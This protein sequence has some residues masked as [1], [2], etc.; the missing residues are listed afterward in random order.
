M[1]ELF[2]SPAAGFDHPIEILEGCH[3][4]IRRNCALVQRV[5]RHVAAKGSDD[6]ARTAIRT[7]MRYFDE[8]GANHHRDE[9]ED[10]FPALE[11]CAT[12]ADEAPL[13][14]LLERLRREH[15]ELDA[16][17]KEMREALEAVA[18]GH[19]GAITADAALRFA[20][21]YETH[22]ALEEASLFPLAR[23]LLEAPALDA[24]GASMAARRGVVPPS[25]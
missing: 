1:D 25:R 24:L 18:G 9:E 21:A 12:G 13:A 6:E 4:R 7:V 17:W 2:P 5:V 8:A 14:A 11:R 22:L 20:R 19:G 10:L 23:R 16:L 15:G 3:Q